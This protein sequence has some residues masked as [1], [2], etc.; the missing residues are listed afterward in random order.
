MEVGRFIQHVEHV[1]RY[2]AVS[3][4]D[5]LV[6]IHVSIVT[7]ALSDSAHSAAK[8]RVLIQFKN[9]QDEPAI[10]T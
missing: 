5:A 7:H 1:V 6:T 4:T 8:K 9:D 10:D 2:N 3:V